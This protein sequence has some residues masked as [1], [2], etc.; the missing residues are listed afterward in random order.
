[1]ITSFTL[2]VPRR[3]KR[4]RARRT[5]LDVEELEARVA[6]AS[7]VA[8]SLTTAAVT[9]G[10]TASASPQAR[11]TTTAPG[12]TGTTTSASGQAPAAGTL[13]TTVAAATSGGV[14][15]EVGFAGTTP[16]VGP[17]PGTSSDLANPLADNATPFSA[18]SVSPV[19]LIDQPLSAAT[20]QVNLVT[21]LPP[22]VVR[23][24]PFYEQPGRDVGMVLGN[25]SPAAPTPQETNPYAIPGQDNAPA[26][27]PAPRITPRPQ[28]PQTDDA[29]VSGAA[30]LP[31]PPAFDASEL[32]PPKPVAGVSTDSF[33]R[34]PEVSFSDAGSRTDLTK[35]GLQDL[36]LA[37]HQP[38]LLLVGGAFLTAGW[39]DMRQDPRDRRRR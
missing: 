38:A 39:Q 33:A 18:L 10:Q 35:H 30:D 28:L 4:R 37:L 27:T 8:P 24:L 22:Y 17:Q 20:T 16:F 21:A 19:T 9:A 26:P 29:G 23:T 3:R 11:V 1:M 31:A 13:Q 12:S 34:A 5:R 15:L 36:S 2:P 7:A 25:A 14:V 6:L 32:T